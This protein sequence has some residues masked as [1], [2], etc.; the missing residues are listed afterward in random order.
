MRGLGYEVLEA[1]DGDNALSAL[2][3]SGAVSLLFTDVVLPGGMTGPDIAKAARRIDPAIKV[4]YMSGYSEAAG[5][6]KGP[7]DAAIDLLK[8]PFPYGELAVRVRRKLDANEGERL[9]GGFGTRVSL[10]QRWAA[11]L[12]RHR[13]GLV[14]PPGIV[15]VLWPLFGR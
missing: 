12:S 6:A 4:L 3:S 9:T 15:N 13:S 7:G 8:K 14:S 2:R 5:P 11:P 1:K 10:S